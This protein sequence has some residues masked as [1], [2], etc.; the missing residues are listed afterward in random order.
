MMDS[1]N[2]SGNVGVGEREGRVASEVVR[3]R[4]FGLSHGMGRSGDVTAVQPKAA[5]SSIIVCIHPL[6]VFL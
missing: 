5:G 1:N 4:H 2:F 6:S 3:R